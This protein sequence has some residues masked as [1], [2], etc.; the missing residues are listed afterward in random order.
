[1]IRFA[2]FALLAGCAT[3]APLPPQSIRVEIPASVPD[4]SR[5]LRPC[6]IEQ[7]KVYSAAEATRVANARGAALVRC[8]ADKVEIA[9]R[10]QEKP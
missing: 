2:P 1:M 6:P 5:W 9:K 3:H 7:P 10:L 4:V 8:N